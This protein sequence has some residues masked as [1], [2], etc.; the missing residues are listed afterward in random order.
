MERNVRT[1]LVVLTLIVSST[2]ASGVVGAAQ[3]GP[4]IA[5]EVNGDRLADGDRVVVPEAN[6]TVHIDGD[7]NLS[8]VVVRIDGED[9]GQYYPDGTSFEQTLDPDLH[10]G[11]NEIRVIATDETDQ[12]NSYRATVHRDSIA[13]F[14]GL[15]EPFTVEPGYAFP[16][17]KTMDAVNVTL[18]G[19]VHDESNITD[20]EARIEGNG[21]VRTTVLA[22]DSSFA[23]NTTLGLG[24]ST[25]AIRAT[26]EFGNERRVQTRMV[27][28][29]EADPSIELT[30]WRAESRRPV[31][32]QIRATDD[33]GLRSL[34][35]HPERQPERDL[36]DPST[37]LFDQGRHDVTRNTTLEF[38][39]ESVYN[40]TFTATDVANNTV[41]VTKKIAYDPITEAE[42]AAPDIRVDRNESGI[43]KDGSYL[44]RAVVSNGS[45]SRVTVESETVPGGNVT[46]HS[47]VYDGPERA[48][49]TIYQRVAL[50]PGR[51]DVQI[52]ATDS[53]GVQHERT[54]RVDTND[55]ASWL[56]TTEPTT[57]AESTPTET[58]TETTTPIV[59]AATAEQE[60][61]LTP[62]TESSVPLS[63]VPI[64]IALL[65]VSVVLA[66]KS[67][68]E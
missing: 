43:V 50:E 27:V 16:A 24:N 32:V 59:P 19:T 23:L 13:P 11:D 63:P 47:V 65:F 29:D 56:A 28:E 22:N 66:R 26:D 35:V 17:N 40:V 14:F 52:R 7:E 30:G 57:T 38:R 68:S 5:V 48:N 55:N 54:I 37:E 6:L 46:A 33:V 34:T 39:F 61:P 1:I 67:K 45:V 49:V 53:F 31:T 60:E 25:L 51:N 12:T 21:T 10:G 4:S 41:V 42:A 64:I 44:L 36:I 9:V 20:F 2:V 8:S 58:T 62:V 15:T 18:N 3:G